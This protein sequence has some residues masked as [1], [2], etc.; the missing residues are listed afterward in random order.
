[1]CT[2]KPNYSKEVYKKHGETIQSYLERT[3]LPAIQTVGGSDSVA[4]LKELKFRW[5]NHI[6]MNGW[7]CKVF[8]V[9][10][11]YHAK[12][13]KLPSLRQVGLIAFKTHVYEHVKV[14]AKDAVIELIYKERDGEIIKKDLIK[15]AVEIYETMGMGSLD[16]YEA[17]LV[18][19]SSR[20][21]EMVYSL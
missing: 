6:I 5:K 21:S 3:V 12:H 8:D 14:G 2:G 9:L 7:Y 11:R 18:S 10:D 1:M 15:N 17:D 20:V 16:V 19:N 13:H 4:L